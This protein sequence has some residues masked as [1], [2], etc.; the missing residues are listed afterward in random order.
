MNRA[1]FELVAN[2]TTGLQEVAAEEPHKGA[3]TLSWVNVAIASSFILVNGKLELDQKR[4]ES[5]E[6]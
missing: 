4:E 5:L 3:P 1:L 6:D 2:V